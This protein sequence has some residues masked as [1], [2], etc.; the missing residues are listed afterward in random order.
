MYSNR[1]RHAPYEKGLILLILQ[2]KLPHWDEENHIL[3][4][5]KLRP[6]N[7][8]LLDSKSQRDFQNLEVYH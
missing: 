5:R 8:P 4:N 6:H 2:E 1:I 3:K 7:N